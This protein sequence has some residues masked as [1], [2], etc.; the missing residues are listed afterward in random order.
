MRK[1]EY[2]EKR[3]APEHFAKVTRTEFYFRKSLEWQYEQ[4]WRVTRLVPTA[5]HVIEI[6]G[7]LP[8]C[9]F[10]FPKE[11]VR[12]VLIGCRASEET[13]KAIVEIV[14]RKKEYANTTLL[15]ASIDPAEFKLN[16]NAL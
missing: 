13:E 14:R 8:I 7:N 5:D 4:E 11:S 2:S 6:E 15:R 16:F 9:L 1:V 3:P 10:N 12:E